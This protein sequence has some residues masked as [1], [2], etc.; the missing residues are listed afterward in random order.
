MMELNVKEEVEVIEKSEI[1][2]AA[3]CSV[4]RRR[5]GQADKR[6]YAMK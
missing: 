2:Q 3:A 6:I 5:K 1:R 4:I